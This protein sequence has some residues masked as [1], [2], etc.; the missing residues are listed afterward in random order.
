MI[1]IA[2]LVR[3]IA[4]VSLST[5]VLISL[6]DLTGVVQALTVVVVSLL[7]GSTRLRLVIVMLVLTLSCVV[8]CDAYAV[9]VMLFVISVLSAIWVLMT[10][11]QNQYVCYLTMT[12]TMTMVLWLSTSLDICQWYVIVSVVGL[13]L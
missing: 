12:V 11:T 3:A 10:G 6:P 5:L 8:S 1:L 13:L 2:L 9:K 7:V 4:V